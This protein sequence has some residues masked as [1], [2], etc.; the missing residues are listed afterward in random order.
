MN[1]L[2]QDIYQGTFRHVTICQGCK[3]ESEMC[4]FNIQMK[5]LQQKMKILRLKNDVFDIQ[6]K[7][8]QQKMKILRLKIDGFGTTRSA[9]RLPFYELQL[10]PKDG[11]NDDFIVQ[12]TTNVALKTRNV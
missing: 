5:I 12:K 4:V 11:K 10:Q 8:L 6:M 1:K 9:T 2:V 7:I 3:K